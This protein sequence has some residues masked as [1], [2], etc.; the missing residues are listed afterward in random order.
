MAATS[1]RASLAYGAVFLAGP[2]TVDAQPVGKVYRLGYLS[3]A[4]AHNPIDQ[5]FERAMK[6]LG[7]VEGAN[8]RLERRY[9]AGRNDQL[10]SAAVELVRLNPDLIV[11]WSPAGTVAVKDATASIPVVFLA[12]GTGSARDVIAGLPRPGGNLTG[13]TFVMSGGTGLEPKFLEMLREL[14]PTLSHVVLLKAPAEESPTTDD[15]PTAA[16]RSLGIRLSIVQLH[17]PADLKGA[18]ARVEKEKPQAIIATASGLLYAYRRE[19]TDFAAR[20]RLPVVYG[21]REAVVDGG[22]MSLSPSLAGIAVRGA[23][24]VDKILKGAKPADLPV[25]QPT[26]FELMI[27][28]KTAKALGLTIPPSLLARADQVIE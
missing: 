6:D 16:A 11:V 21:L 17:V 13:I 7:Y 8:L 12:G 1:R 22:L 5:A 15:A 26:N 3:P 25:E 18:F 19:V 10:P 2:P 28:L 24:Y 9:T 14:I 4:P 23:F 20:N 27:N